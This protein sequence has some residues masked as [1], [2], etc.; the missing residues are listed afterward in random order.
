MARQLPLV[1][2]FEVAA[3]CAARFQ[4]VLDFEALKLTAFAAG[5]Q[6]AMRV[7]LIARRNVMQCDR[8]SSGVCG[9]RCALQSVLTLFEPPSV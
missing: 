4:P 3:A 2:C 5:L 1:R 6:M 7:G 8:S 9:S